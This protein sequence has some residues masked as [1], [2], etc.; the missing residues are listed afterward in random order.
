MRWM[1][2]AAPLGLLLGACVEMDDTPS[3]VVGTS[4]DVATAPGDYTGYRVV[5]PC[6]DTYVNVGVIGTGSVA[7]TETAQIAAV[8]NDLAA[9][10]RDVPSIW[11]HGGYGLSCEPGVGT[12]IYTDN[13]RDV[14]ALIVRVG[15]WL[16]DRDLALQVGI[17]VNSQPV[18]VA[19]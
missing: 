2:V 13:W 5:T 1:S 7:I 12:T 19:D 4:G 16:R 8:G 3:T 17:G 14:D 9:A 10:L 15:E 11:G 18:A 6:E